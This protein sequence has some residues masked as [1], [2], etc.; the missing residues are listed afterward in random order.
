MSRPGDN[1]AIAIVVAISA[2]LLFVF[3][4]MAVDIGAAYAER[5]A[6][7]NSA[8]AAALG[9]ANALPDMGG[10]TSDAMRD[11]VAYVEV[12]LSEPEEG[13]EAAWAACEDPDHLALVSDLHGP[14]VSVSAFGTRIRVVIPERVVPTVLAGVIGISEIRVSAFAEA[15]IEFVYSAGVLPFG[16]PGSRANDTEVC[17]KTGPNGHAPAMPPCT[18]S[19]EGNFGPLDFSW[20]GNAAAGTIT[21]CDGPDSQQLVVNTILGIDHPLSVYTGTV[22]DDRTA[23]T[24][25]ADPGDRPNQAFSQPGFGSALD[26][27]LVSGATLNG[28]VLKGRLANTPFATVPVRNGRPPLDN[29]PLWSFIDPELAFGVDA[30]ASCD[31]GGITN[32]TGM[33]GCLDDYKAQLGCP[34]GCQPL[35]TADDNNDGIPDLQQSPRFAYVPQLV[36]MLMDNGNTPHQFVAFRPVFLQTLFF[37]CNASNCNLVWNPGEPLVGTTNRDVQ[38]MTS[39]LLPVGAL[40]AVINDNAPGTRGTPSVVLH[41]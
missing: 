14:C 29:R 17:L 27:G 24:A 37:G 21:A 4:A 13:W 19:N 1:G 32:R 5:R 33:A 38:A 23:C 7:Q 20:F 16:L 15:Q 10:T 26:P 40:P 34:G 11:A 9:G 18:G 2:V 36:A 6:D 25:G 41:R 3:G 31:P 8:D 28:R 30:P 35:F 12:N 39:F 22:R